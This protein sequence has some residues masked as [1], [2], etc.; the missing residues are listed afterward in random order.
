M[1]SFQRNAAA[2]SNMLPTWMHEFYQVPNDH[3]RAQVNTTTEDVLW[4]AKVAR[5]APCRWL[6]CPP[7]RHCP[8]A[9]PRRRPPQYLSYSCAAAWSTTS[10]GVPLKPLYQDSSL[11]RTARNACSSGAPRMPVTAFRSSA[12]HRR[13][14]EIDVFCPHPHDLS[15]QAAQSASFVL[16]SAL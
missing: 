13:H 5:A 7:P 12:R 10:D 9:L 15:M 1:T 4:T 16:C 11:W 3:G 14:D 2:H 6:R 8:L